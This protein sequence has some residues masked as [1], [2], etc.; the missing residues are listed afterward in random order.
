MT[1]DLARKRAKLEKEL[2]ALEKAEREREEKRQMVVGRAV[3]AAAESDPN[4][5]MQLRRVL[6]ANVTKKRERDLLGLS[7]GSSLPPAH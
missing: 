6:D 3:L 4:L 5:K 2:A 1:D 7:A